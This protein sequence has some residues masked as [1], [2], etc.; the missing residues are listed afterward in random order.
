MEQVQSGQRSHT[1]LLLEHHPVITLGRGAHQ[2]HLLVTREELAGRGVELYESGR[3]GDITYHGPGQLVGYPILDLNSLGPDLHGYIRALEELIIQTLSTFGLEGTRQEKLTGVWMPPLDAR[4]LRKIAAI[5]IR[6][7]RWVT[8]HG[9][10]LN[11]NTALDPFSLIVP[12]G[13]HGKAV[14]SMFQELESPVPMDSVTAA[15][16]ASMDSVFHL[17]PQWLPQEDLLTNVTR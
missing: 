17:R 8:S 14:T 10:A 11:V 2:E 9:F 6:V 13:L 12:C 4:P 5:G 16:A 3:G 1:L 7:Q 15:I